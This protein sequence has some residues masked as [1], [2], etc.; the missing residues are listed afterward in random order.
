MRKTELSQ[1]ALRIRRRTEEPTLNPNWKTQLF[2][3]LAAIAITTAMDAS[4]LSAFSALPLL[5]L[6]GLFWYWQRLSRA[7]A[8]FAWGR[9]RDYALAVVYPLS[10]LGVVVIIAVMT[11]AIDLAGANWRKAGANAILITVSTVLVALLTEEGFFRGWLWASLKRSGQSSRRVL[12][13]T[14]LAFSLWHLS[15][16]TL[17]TGFNPPAAQV[18][19]FMINAALLGAIWGMLRWLS[20]SVIVTSVSHGLWNGLDYALFGFGSHAGALGIKQTGLYG[21]E[22]GVLG[23]VLN[24]AFATVL[25]LCVKRRVAG[26]SSP[27]R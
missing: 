22:V 21:P 17:P 10:V 9:L 14:S 18:P 27:D 8:G 15:A 23:L 11:G 5:P 6:L 12:L 25:W 26:S 24:L 1:W 3:V 2:G 7:E 4:G 16:V 20:G 19:V 13:W